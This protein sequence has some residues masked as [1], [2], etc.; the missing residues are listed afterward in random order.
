[1]PTEAKVLS[2]IEGS[3]DPWKQGLAAAQAAM[4]EVLVASLAQWVCC[5]L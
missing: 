4:T 3:M 2:P 5:V 1:M